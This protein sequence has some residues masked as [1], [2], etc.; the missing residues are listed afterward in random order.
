MNYNKGLP[1]P[2]AIPY[3]TGVNS[4]GLT[5]PPLQF[6]STKDSGSSNGTPENQEPPTISGPSVQAPTISGQSGQ[7]PIIS[8]QIPVQPGHVPVKSGHVPIQPA[9]PGQAPG[10]APVQSGPAPVQSGPS[11]PDRYIQMTYPNHLQPAPGPGPGP[12]GTNSA[13]T[14]V[15][16][17]PQFSTASPSGYIT[18]PSGPHNTGANIPHSTGYSNTGAYSHNTGPHNTGSSAYSH[19]TGAY[20]PGPQGSFTGYPSY[21][22]S[23]EDKTS[24]DYSSIINYTISPSLKRKRRHNSLNTGILHDE[25]EESKL[26]CNVCGK[27]FAKPYNLKSHMKSHSSEKPFKCGTCGKDFARSHD[28]K[29]HEMLHLG[30]KNFKCEGFLNDGKTKWGCGKRFARSDALSRHFRT[31]TGWLCIKPLMDEA[32]HMESNDLINTLVNH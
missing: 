5:L 24:I 30:E 15:S 4:Y 31:E 16:L 3:S 32:K 10:Q 28:K 29:R 22:D 1:L 14:S 25:Y 13:S 8:G 17:S 7:A 2:S 23:H 20:N 27:I 21:E 19:N 11:L 12:H 6:Y 26:P 18:S 9:P